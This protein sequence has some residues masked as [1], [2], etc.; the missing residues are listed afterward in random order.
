[1]IQK[2]TSELE[3][4]MLEEVAAFLFWWKNLSLKCL[5]FFCFQVLLIFSSLQAT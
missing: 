5:F 3:F 2:K 1:M 4:H